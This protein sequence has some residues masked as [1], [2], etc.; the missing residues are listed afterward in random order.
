MEGELWPEHLHQAAKRGIPVLL[1]NARM[2]DRAFHYYKCLKVLAKPIFKN[3]AKVLASSEQSKRRYA[4][5]G[6]DPVDIEITG[7]IK[8]DAPIPNI[9]SDGET[10]HL[11]GELGFYRDDLS[12]DRARYNMRR[13][14]LAR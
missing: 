2:S 11:L 5:L 13:F 8:C 3:L 14:H 4:V 7:N 1:I 9:L 10:S 12:G 6:V